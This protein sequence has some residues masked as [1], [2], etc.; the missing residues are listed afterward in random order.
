ME[1]ENISKINEEK[2]NDDSIE[3]SENDEQ[4]E[5]PSSILFCEDCLQ[6]PLYEID[7]RN[8]IIYLIHD[9]KGNKKEILFQSEMKIK[10]RK[11]PLSP[12]FHCNKKCDSICIECHKNIC[13]NCKKSH[14]PD[15]PDESN[16]IPQI[17]YKTEKNES[18]LKKYIISYND[19]QFMCRIHFIKYEYFCP[20]CKINLREH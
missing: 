7:L 9:C 3:K 18:S 19:I 12:C 20:I 1:S 5:N 2:K 17:I 8:G 11:Y 14:L 16:E 13:L 4:M 10:N 6:I 15:E